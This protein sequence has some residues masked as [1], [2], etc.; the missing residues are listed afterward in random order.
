M[1]EKNDRAGGAI[2]VKVGYPLS[3]AENQ[4][5]IE[6]EH[7]KYDVFVTEPKIMRS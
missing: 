2:S 5:S 1:N 3:R 7:A 4:G 6:R